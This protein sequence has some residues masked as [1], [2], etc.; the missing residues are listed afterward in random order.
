MEPNQVHLVAAS[1][2]CDSQQI[3]DAFEPRFAGQIVR[4]VGDGNLR[5]RIHDDVALIHPVTTTHLYTGTL[6][7]TNAAFDYPEPDPR[8]KTFGEHHMEPYLMATGRDGSQAALSRRPVTDRT[9][10]PAPVQTR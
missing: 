5:N 10:A 6:P 4:D 2:S 9:V 1:V 8:A 3:I 7:D